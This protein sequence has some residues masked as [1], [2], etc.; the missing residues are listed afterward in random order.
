M[1]A[2]AQAATTCIHVPRLRPYAFR[3]FSYD[4]GRLPVRL[5]QREVALRLD[6][7]GGLE[8]LRFNEYDRG[9]MHPEAFREFLPHW[10]ARALAP[11]R[12]RAHTLRAATPPDTPPD[13]PRRPLPAA[14]P[15]ATRATPPPSLPRCALVAMVNREELVLR[16]LLQPGECL[17]VNNHRVLHG[18][19]SFFDAEGAERKMIG[20]YLSRDALDS[21]LRTAGLLEMCG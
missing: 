5:S 12:A 7:M 14:P 17:V 8:Q 16:T 9:D 21:R 19:T 10:Y 20:C 2:R 13:A 3:W 15:N 18:R 1:H 6:A 4:E 11:P